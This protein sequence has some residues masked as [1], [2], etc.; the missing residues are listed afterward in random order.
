VVI[1][2]V[3]NVKTFKA[4]AMLAMGPRKQAATPDAFSR[5]SITLA[6]FSAMS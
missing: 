5:T 6:T 2:Y 3:F 1:E 4:S